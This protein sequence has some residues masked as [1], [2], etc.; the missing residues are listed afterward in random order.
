VLYTT[1]GR[2]GLG[3]ESLNT[4][5]M[6]VCNSSC[7]GGANRRHFPAGAVPSDIVISELMYHPADAAP[8]EFLELANSGPSTE[9]LSGWCLTTE[10]QI[11]SII[12]T[13]TT[14]Y[15][16]DRAVWGGRAISRFT[17]VL[18]AGI[19]DRRRVAGTEV[20]KFDLLHYLFTVYIV[21]ACR[22]ATC[23]WGCCR[24]ANATG[25]N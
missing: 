6:R 7:A 14:E 1:S 25:M 16:M 23:S 8:V 4:R 5:R 12:S 21:S 24:P 20:R 10:A 19:D 3:D 13:Y 15:N 22:L 18:E 17:D 11:D 2:G 9:D